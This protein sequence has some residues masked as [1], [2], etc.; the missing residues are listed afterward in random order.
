MS[1]E[2]KQFAIARSS[3]GTIGLITSS[4]AVEH[5]YPDGNKKNVWTGV[6]IEDNTFRVERGD[7]TQI[8]KAKI[9]NFWSSSNP[10]VI[11]HINPTHLADLLTS[12]D[13]SAYADAF[14]ENSKRA[15]EIEESEQ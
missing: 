2:V 12:F 8:V 9:G 5:T 11:G 3:T 4:E 6:V 1:K 7:E 14:E 15:T 10:D 13:Y